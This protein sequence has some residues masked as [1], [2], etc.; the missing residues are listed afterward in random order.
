VKVAAITAPNMVHVN[1]R[2]ADV[3]EG[4][5]T[6]PWPGFWWRLLH[7]IRVIQ[8]VAADA[9]LTQLPKFH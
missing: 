6:F 9:K 1:W 8:C 3:A 4:Y 5:G 2:R 7:G